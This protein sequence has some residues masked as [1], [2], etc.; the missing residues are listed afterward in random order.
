VIWLTVVALPAVLAGD[1]DPAM[2]TIIVSF[3]PEVIIVAV[4]PWRY[5]WQRYVTAK[6]DPW[7]GATA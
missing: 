3:A 7:R 1:V 2:S 6:A 5:V 4:T